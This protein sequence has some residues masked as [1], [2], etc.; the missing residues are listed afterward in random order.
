MG[1]LVTIGGG[2]H[3]SILTMCHYV[4]PPSGYDIEGPGQMT[5]KCWH[6]TLGLPNLQK[7][8]S[9]KLPLFKNYHVSSI[10]LQQQKQ[11][12]YMLQLGETMKARSTQGSTT[13][14]S[15]LTN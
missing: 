15:S 14:P 6:H 13:K 3:F 10:L 4:V 11:P 8:D 7:S 1:T 12:R 2:T 5:S 9:N